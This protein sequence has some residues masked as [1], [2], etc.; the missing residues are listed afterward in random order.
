MNSIK[1]GSSD[2]PTSVFV[3]KRN[4]KLTLKQ[5]IQKTKYRLKRAHVER[6]LSSQSHTLDEVMDYI[7]KVHGFTK[8]NA[9]SDDVM[10][11]YRQMRASFL[12]RYVPDLLG[13]YAVLPKLKSTD[14]EEIRAFME[15]SQQ[16]IQKAM[17][18]P[19]SEFDIDFHK[20]T[21]DLGNSKGEMHII[22]EKKYAYIGGGASGSKKLLRK[23]DRLNKDIFKYYGVNRED[24]DSKSERYENVVRALS[25]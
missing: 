8:V 12:I 4:A 6:T 7:V 18:I 13:T 9:N 14:E 10:E 15:K 24:I 23:F 19:V 16:R 20:Y 21:K 25:R 2:G 11:E 17:E 5:R 3:L 1:I 22:I